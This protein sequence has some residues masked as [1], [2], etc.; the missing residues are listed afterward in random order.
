MRKLINLIVFV[1]V[2][3]I[4]YALSPF[5]YVP[6]QV[7]SS[8]IS[9]CGIE[10]PDMINSLQNTCLYTL[11]SYSQCS[12]EAANSLSTL[13]AGSIGKGAICTDKLKKARLLRIYQS[14]AAQRK[15]QASLARQ[16]REVSALIFPSEDLK[17]VDVPNVD[18]EFAKI[19]RAIGAPQTGAPN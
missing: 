6:Y 5:R 15:D 18:E 3:A 9:A 7:I 8:A 14:M 4:I 17:N 11:S 1:F 12:D 2:V 16:F 19:Q 10:N 13:E